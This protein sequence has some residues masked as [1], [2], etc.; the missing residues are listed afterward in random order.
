MELLVQ[1]KTTLLNEKF[2]FCILHM[3]W[4]IIKED[5]FFMEARY[6]VKLLKNHNSS[7]EQS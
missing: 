6:D 4:N 2:V 1:K 7:I 5:A 3:R